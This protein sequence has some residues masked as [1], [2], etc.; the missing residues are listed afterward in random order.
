ME[1]RAWTPGPFI[2]PAGR[3]GALI[4]AVVAVCAL[5]AWPARAQ[6]PLADLAIVKGD[7]PTGGLVL[8]GTPGQTLTYGI[9]VRNLGPD[10]A[11]GILVED[12][13]PSGVSPLSL[14][15]GCSPGSGNKVFCTIPDL[16]PFESMALGLPA[17][18]STP[19]ALPNTVVVSAATADPTP[20]NNSDQILTGVQETTTTGGADLAV[21]SSA[22]PGTLKLPKEIVYTVSVRN[23][24]PATASNVRLIDT[25]L[26]PP[27]STLTLESLAL[28][29]PGGSCAVLRA[30]VP[31]GTAVPPVAG[32]DKVNVVCGLGN[33]APGETTHLE[34]VVRP[35]KP[36]LDGFSNGAGA[37]SFTPDP[38]L[39]NNETLAVVPRA[40]LIGDVDG[41]GLVT[42]SDLAFVESCKK[43][44]IGQV[45]SCAH[46]DVN[47]DGAV[48]G[49]DASLVKKNISTTAGTG[50]PTPTV[51]TFPVMPMGIL[52][53]ALT[54]VFPLT[55]MHEFIEK[56]GLLEV[57]QF[58]GNDAPKT[59]V[60]TSK[61]S[62][63]TSIP[64]GHLCGAS[65][66][67]PCVGVIVTFP[68][69]SRVD[70]FH[71]ATGDSPFFTLQS[72]GPLPE[73]TR[74]AVF[75]GN[76]TDST[77]LF[78]SI[79][80][81]LSQNPQV[82]VD[83]FVDRNGLWIDDTGTYVLTPRELTAKR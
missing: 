26:A 3:L 51:Q 75:G 65:G 9:V 55:D 20:G 29:P 10:P 72:I 34:L 35:G 6:S 46:A 17:A 22:A 28:S 1:Q 27:G 39:A 56:Y 66:C 60:G 62:T 16:Q 77:P 50:T 81:F 79:D 64:A 5:S 2:E 52:S 38:Q 18:A 30:R 63:F 13:L 37:Y 8:I 70:V 53:L 31:F 54:Y 61:H 73:G 19:G 80:V 32:V 43:Q 48:K 42:L 14:P 41:D 49:N 71:F 7:L 36:R 59:G 44:D 57:D 33:L 23:D 47:G 15:S 82:T 24:G 12:T 25:L 58:R 21:S 76:D 68:G 4:F 11:T 83:G 78:N 45:P 74:V 67:N 40:R 69:V